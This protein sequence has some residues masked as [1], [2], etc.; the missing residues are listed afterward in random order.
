MPTK[1]DLRQILRAKQSSQKPSPSVASNVQNII[2]YHTTCKSIGLYVPMEYEPDLMNL[3]QINPDKIFAL[4]KIINGALQFVQCEAVISLEQSIKFSLLQEPL[5]NKV[6]LPNLLIIPGIA[7]DIKGYR[8]G[9]G[10][11]HYD[12]Y[13]SKNNNI[14]TIGVCFGD[15]LLERLPNEDHDCKMDYIITEHSIIKI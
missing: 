6:I 11:G 7:F 10:K 15:N 13:L 12:R 5:G 4:P 1:A 9:L 2:D 14:K 3:L 8:L